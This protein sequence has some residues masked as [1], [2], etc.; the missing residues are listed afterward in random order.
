M[1]RTTSSFTGSSLAVSKRS[2]PVYTQH[3]AMTLH[4]VQPFCG[5]STIVGVSPGSA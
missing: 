3:A 4:E 1:K 5:C 2:S